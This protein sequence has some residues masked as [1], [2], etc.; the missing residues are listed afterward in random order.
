M[1]L[2]SASPAKPKPAGASRQPLLPDAAPATPNIRSYTTRF[3]I[4]FQVS[5]LSF[6]QSM[7]WISFSPIANNAKEFY[8]VDDTTIAWW[9]NIG[10]VGAI[11]TAIPAI[12]FMADDTGLKLVCVV[13]AFAQAFAM[14]GRLVPYLVGEQASAVGVIVVYVAQLVIGMTGPIV[15]A[16][17]PLLSALWFPQAERTQSTAVCCLSNNFGSAAGFLIG[18]LLVRAGDDV[19][20]LLYAH[21]AI[22]S[23]NLLLILAHF[24]ARPP[25]PPSISQLQSKKPGPPQALGG[26]WDVLNNRNYLLI[27]VAGGTINGVF[28]SWSGSFDQIL[29]NVS[30]RWTQSMCG[31]LGFAS[32]VAFIVGGLV[33]GPVADR[34]PWNR[35]MHGLMLTL[36]GLTAGLMALFTIAMPTTFAAKPVIDLSFEVVFALIVASGMALGAC[37]PLV[38]EIGAEVTYPAPESTSA[39]IV[40]LILNLASFVYLFITPMLLHAKVLNIVITGCA[41]AA[42]LLFGCAD[43]KYLRRDREDLSA[44]A[45]NS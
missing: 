35:R 15:M 36:A 4:L 12:K 14:V 31:W 26:M 45:I 8:G 24:P 9:L 17:P 6:N 13:C 39:N 27:A 34:A 1:G 40:V 5:F 33:V 20:H 25:T 19:P 18:P 43:V 37:L 29:Q 32:T 28:N 16:A 41:V 2:V 23:A 7:F 3:W 11:V 21:A 38:Y 10:V 44:L 42:V 22:A 30:G